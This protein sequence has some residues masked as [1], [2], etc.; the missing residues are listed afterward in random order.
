MSFTNQQ[1]IQE[2]I[3]RYEEVEITPLPD[4]A[5][6]VAV[7]SWL[8]F[9]G[10]ATAITIVGRLLNIPLFV[11]FLGYWAMG[12]ILFVGLMMLWTAYRYR[13]K[14]YA[15]REHDIM[16]QR[17]VIW[18]KRTILPFNRVQHVETQQGVLQRKFKLTTLN[19][20]TAGGQRADIA[21]HGM[22]AEITEGIKEMLL[23]RI[24]AEQ[25]TNG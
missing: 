10:I 21:I 24:Q 4:A 6:W 13:F 1:V 18:R 2:E 3:P 16:F 25:T 17:G 23:S 14:G 19:V 5:M 7:I 22:D 9:F 15:V 11:D 20:F 12:V 8:I